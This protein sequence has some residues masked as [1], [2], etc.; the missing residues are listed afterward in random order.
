MRKVIF[1]LWFL[2]GL[3]QGQAQQLSLT[4]PPT[5]TQNEVVATWSWSGGPVFLHVPLVLA[6]V[7]ESQTVATTI[8]TPKVT[9]PTQG[10]IPFTI[11]EPG[12]FQAILS[13][14]LHLPAFSVQTTASFTSISP[15]TQQLRQ[16]LPQL[17]IQHL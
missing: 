17:P 10:T 1:W 5:V 3:V 12:S 2:N 15:P 6:I 4:V 9:G 8:T 7:Q 16:H 11:S 14:Q 13:A